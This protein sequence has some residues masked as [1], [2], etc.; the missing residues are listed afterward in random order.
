MDPSKA[1]Y[2][3]GSISTQREG[4]GDFGTSDRTKDGKLFHNVSE[5]WLYDS[6]SAGK[7]LRVTKA[8]RLAAGGEEEGEEEEIAEEEKKWE[9]VVVE[10]VE[11][12]QVEGKVVVGMKIA[13]KRVER[14]Y[15]REREREEN[16]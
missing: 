15:K 6:V 1:N 10:P 13:V 11:E 4:L 8:Y 14:I 2:A 9:D 3:I 7:K 12:E 16:K 5:K